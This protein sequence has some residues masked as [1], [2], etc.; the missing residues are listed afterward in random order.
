MYLLVYVNTYGIKT[1]IYT[2]RRL[3]IK[4]LTVVISKL[5]NLE[6]FSPSFSSCVPSKVSAASALPRRKCRRRQK[7]VAPCGL[8]SSHPRRPSGACP[9][10]QLVMPHSLPYPLRSEHHK[11]LVPAPVEAGCPGAL[12]CA[13][14]SPQL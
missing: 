3:Y 6:Y 13:T 8:Q 14:P 2:Y 10:L 1:H 4:M 9:S 7:S 11:V 12:A 5:W